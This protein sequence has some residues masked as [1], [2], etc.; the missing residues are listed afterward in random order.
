LAEKAHLRSLQF[1]RRNSFQKSQTVGTGRTLVFLD[2]HSKRL[3]KKIGSLGLG[4]DSLLILCR[5]ENT[6]LA[7]KKTPYPVFFLPELLSSEDIE[8]T[9]RECLDFIQA[10]FFPDEEDKD[11]FLYKGIRLGYIIEHYL[12][13]IFMRVFRDVL[14][15]LKAARHFEHDRMIVASSEDFPEAARAAFRGGGMAFQS[16]SWG[17]PGRFF[18]VMRRFLAGMKNQWRAMPAR[19]L[20][21]EPFQNLIVI[22]GSFLW[23]QGMLLKGKPALAGYAKKWLFFSAEQHT[24]DIYEKMAGKP[25][26]GFLKCGTFLR[27]R[28][29][30]LRKLSPLEGSFRPFM[31]GRV[32]AAFNHFLGVWFGLSGDDS[33]R[34]RFKFLGVNYWPLVRRLIKYN[35]LIS[36]PRHFLNYLVAEGAF[37]DHPRGILIIGADQPPY[38][39]ALV[40]AAR[41]TGVKSMV[42]QHGVQAGINGHQVI[43]ADIYAGWGQRTVD[44]F[45][46]YGKKGAAEKVSVT[47]APRYDHYAGAGSRD[48]DEILK[49]LGLPAGKK[50]VLVLTEWTQDFSVSSTGMPDI[51][52]VEAAINAAEEIGDICHV[53][54]KPHP[55]GD[56]ELLRG[57][58]EKKSGKVSLVEGHLD[59]LL[60]AADLCVSFYS[61]CVLEAMFFETPSIVFDSSDSVEYV[62]YVSMGAALGAKNREEMTRAMRALLFNL[63]RRA[64]IIAGQKRFIEYTAYKMDGKS[65]ERVSMLIERLLN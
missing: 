7:F 40:L 42:I 32:F 35:V 21:I 9:D 48:R 59:E 52:M 44:W 4:G 28:R 46:E 37:R 29:T 2:G 64:E 30:R 57:L 53:V 38:Y 63:S 54:I 25:G 36:M 15:A 33:F 23:K 49:G 16:W 27:M 62:P 5:D 20:I 39:R 34:A 55:S 13:P 8:S 43:G 61:T 56:V 6:Y 3:Q 17:R 26:W 10:V 45:K 24:C 18:Y 31:A 58:T 14:L 50:L 41:Q 47:G 65:A 22:M 12:V 11:P 51:R 19:D 1:F 60:F